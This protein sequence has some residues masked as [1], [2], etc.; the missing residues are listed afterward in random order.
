[1]ELQD[2][3]LSLPSILGIL[4]SIY[5]IYN[6][7]NFSRLGYIIGWFLIFTVGCEIYASY[8]ADLKKN[9]LP[10]LHL[11]TLGQFI[12][13]S[14]FFYYLFRLLEWSYFK[15]QYIYLAIGLIIFNSIFIQN[16]YTYN[17]Y[18][19]TGVQ[20]FIIILCFMGY[21]LLTVKTYKNWDN[22]SIK[23]LI[24]AILL[25]CVISLTLYLFSHQIM[26]LEESVQKKIW[27][28]NVSGNILTQILYIFALIKMV[29]SKKRLK[30]N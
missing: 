12:F 4:G 8:M 15:I 16:I 5:F 3:I 7:K 21:F 23:I 13:C 24:A 1:M 2:F 10:G 9:N 30:M 29:N 27:M 14:L 18:S 25:S 11:Y 6:Y 22:E 28:I 17:S 19:K 26:A 20:L